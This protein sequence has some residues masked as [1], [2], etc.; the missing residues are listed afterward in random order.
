VL[1]V[2]LKGEV[3]WAPLAGVD[4][5]IAYP[6]TAAVINNDSAQNIR[7]IVPPEEWKYSFDNV[8]FRRWIQPD[9]ARSHLIYIGISKN[10]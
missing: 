8:E 3:T 2:S 4:T 10:A 9:S 7:F 1:A 5:V 6:G